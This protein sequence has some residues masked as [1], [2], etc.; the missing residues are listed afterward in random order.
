MLLISVPR[1]HD[2]AM[3]IYSVAK[4]W[5]IIFSVWKLTRAGGN[6]YKP[7]FIIYKIKFPG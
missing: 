6:V 3:R 7:Y 1:R 2:E 5:R 4:A